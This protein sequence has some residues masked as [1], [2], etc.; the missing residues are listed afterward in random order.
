MGMTQGQFGQVMGV[1]G[2]TVSNWE[3]GRMSMVGRKLA[4]LHAENERLRAEVG[5]LCEE[6]KKSR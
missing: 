1:T 3:R 5:R 2:A 4:E 6:L